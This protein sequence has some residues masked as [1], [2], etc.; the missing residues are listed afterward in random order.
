M[1]YINYLYSRFPEE[2]YPPKM[3][4]A[5]AYKLAVEIGMN[6][7]SQSRVF[8]AMLARD[9]E[10]NFIR[11]VNRVEF[12]SQFF[13]AVDVCIVTNGSKDRTTDLCSE[14][15][16]SNPRVCTIV[17]EHLTEERL[18][19]KSLRRRRL[20]ANLRNLYLDVFK[21]EHE[22]K[23][24]NY[25]MVMDS[26]LYGGFSYDGVFHSIGMM[27][28]FRQ[29]KIIAANGITYQG[30]QRLFYDS[31]AFRYFNDDKYHADE[32]INLLKFDRGEPLIK[33]NSAFGGL[34]IYKA[35]IISHYTKYGEHDVDH[36]TLHQA[37]RL[38]GNEIY[39][40]PSMIVCYKKNRLQF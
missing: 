5:A 40:N 20:M 21:A 28:A 30:G 23:P 35:D 10:D 38:Q 31:W 2:L 11:L 13:N 17:P 36:F 18:Q 37:L 3:E 27:Q 1:N 22:A 16:Q 8:L 34:A 4:H 9:I 25:L 32:E 6:S 33:V 12:F 19:D 14:W 7:A 29:A 39:L 26:D 15:R 24:Y